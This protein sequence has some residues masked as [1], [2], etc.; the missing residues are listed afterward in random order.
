MRFNSNNGDECLQDKDCNELGLIMN[1]KHPLYHLFNFV[2]R[3]YGNNPE[4]MVKR[5][6]GI[7]GMEAIEGL[8]KNKSWKNA[9]RITRYALTAGILGAEFV[10]KLQTYIRNM[11]RQKADASE[12]RIYIISDLLQI[13]KNHPLYGNIPHCDIE[14]S[15]ALAQWLLSSPK[16]SMAK[17]MGY[18]ALPSLEEISVVDLKPLDSAK[19]AVLVEYEGNSYAYELSLRMGLFGSYDRCGMSVYGMYLNEETYGKLESTLLIEFAKTLEIEKNIIRF[20]PSGCM[21][22][23]EPRRV[24]NDLLNQFDVDKLI[25]EI[26]FV[27]K[28]GRKR[29]YA[30]VGRQGTGKSSILRSVEQKLT[31]YMIVHLSAEDFSF[32]DQLRLR[33]NVLKVFQPLLIMIEDMESCGIKEKNKMTGAF[34]ECID[35]VNEGLNM[36]IMYTVNDT[37]LI[38]RTIINRPGRSDKVI[39]IFPPRTP[40]EALMVLETRL[41]RIQDIYHFTIPE[42]MFK[43][44]QIL[45][46]MKRCVEE[47]FTQAEITNA[48]AEQA[49]IDMGVDQIEYNLANF[50]EYLNKAV[51]HQLDTRQAIKNC[52]FDNKDPELKES[53]C[54]AIAV[55]MANKEPI[56]LY[57]SI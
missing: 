50:I 3:E 54:E 11:R 33:F 2:A 13:P 57:G 23:A 36:V 28:N 46:V 47:D 10:I 8:V 24:M 45:N 19:I 14:K 20:E 1:P 40:E 5:L 22:F 37:S 49:V 18:Y 55:P 6:V 17:I 51:A 27:L 35:E 34:L 12:R 29:T 7:L 26:E 21:M 38:H 16:L 9:L 48:V 15:P 42:D 44:R 30:F 32:P 41:K 31:K 43:D 4:A 53:K 39:E 25:S 52:S 56:G